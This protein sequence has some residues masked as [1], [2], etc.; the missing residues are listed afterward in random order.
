MSKEE[1]LVV[2][3]A[4]SDII[5]EYADRED[6]R[7][8]PMEVTM[9]DGQVFDVTYD[10]ANMGMD[11]FYRKVKDGL[12]AM[13]TAI[14]PQRYLDFFRPLLAE[15][16]D[17]LY[18]CF[19]SGMSSTYSNAVLAAQQ[20]R[21]EFPER[22]LLVVDS[23][24]AT[25]GQGYQTYYCAVNRDRGMSIEAN[26]KW[27]EDTR[28][29]VQYTWVVS[30]LMHLNRGG[31]L[32]KTAAVVGTALN[33]KPVGDID[34]TGHLVSIGRARGRH[35]SIT[36]LCDMLVKSID[37]PDDY[38][39][40]V[41]HCDCIEDAEELRKQILASGKASKVVI[42]RTGPVVGTHLGPSGLTCFY[43]CTRRL[44]SI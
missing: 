44:T 39:V 20:L 6:I 25:G 38:P 2:T 35:A 12:F 31:R 33:I 37:N 15:G 14:T 24:G 40:L 36:K 43:F 1:Y 29:H 11:E 21:D 32:S 27:L 4:C 5:P 30:D 9:T 8:I 28:K 22:K 34:D 26:A 23:L 17:I 42:G 10:N 18:N 16:H 19:T 3:D 13:T 41:C 7:V